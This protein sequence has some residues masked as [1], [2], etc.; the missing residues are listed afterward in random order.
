MALVGD[1]WQ[2]CCETGG[3]AGVGLCR[4]LT[5]AAGAGRKEEASG[6]VVGGWVVV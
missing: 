4:G 2:W 6:E 1:V 5:A 3:T